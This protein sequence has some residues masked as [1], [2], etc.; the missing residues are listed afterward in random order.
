M[1]EK[2]VNKKS[3][4]L[5]VAKKAGVTIGTV[6]H[7]INGTAPITDKTKNKVHKA[8]NE[9]NYKPNAMARGL[10]RSQSKMIG[11]LVPDITNEYYSLI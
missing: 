3:T 5:D 4:M 7:V 1:D 11:L 10:R 9:L 6:S 2:A 8:I